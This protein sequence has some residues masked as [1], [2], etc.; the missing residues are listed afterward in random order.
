MFL[1]TAGTPQITIRTK[2]LLDSLFVSQIPRLQ[3]VM[4]MEINHSPVVFSALHGSSL[5]M[6]AYYQ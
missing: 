2:S 4:G 3:N 5:Y 1:F 6:D